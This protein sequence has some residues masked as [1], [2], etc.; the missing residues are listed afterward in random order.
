MEMKKYDTIE[1]VIKLTIQL[2][3][4]LKDLCNLF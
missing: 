4:L 2:L 3:R 1:K